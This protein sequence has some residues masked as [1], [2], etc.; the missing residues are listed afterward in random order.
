LTAHALTDPDLRAPA[1]KA[2]A[3]LD[4]PTRKD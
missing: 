2:C 4:T 3:A 1:S